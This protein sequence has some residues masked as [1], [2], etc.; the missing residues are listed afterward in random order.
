GVALGQTADNRSLARNA[1]LPQSLKGAGWAFVGGVEFDT[2][3][4]GAI[5]QIIFRQ[6]EIDGKR[7]VRSGRDDLILRLHLL[8][9]LLAHFEDVGATDG[10][11]LQAL[12]ED[13][14]GA[15]FNFF[16]PGRRARGSASDEHFVAE[17]FLLIFGQAGGAPLE[18][19]KDA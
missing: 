19:T 7:F 9:D 8:T 3:I 16:V 13:L 11:L 12:A 10:I 17:D 6:A 14:V 4:K 15:G 1:E 2:E 5:T 18:Q